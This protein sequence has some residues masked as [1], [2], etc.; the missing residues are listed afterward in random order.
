MQDI[1][2]SFFCQILSRQ[3]MKNPWD[4]NGIFRIRHL[5]SSTYYILFFLK[6]FHST[7]D[8][9]NKIGME[10]RLGYAPKFTVQ[11]SLILIYYSVFLVD[12]K[13]QRNEALFTCCWDNDYKDGIIARGRDTIFNLVGCMTRSGHFTYKM[14]LLIPNL[15]HLGN[16]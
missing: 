13:G 14:P 15:R 3:R 6:L 16:H 7:M 4:I 12:E 9:K 5:Y 10:K 8:K 2:R 11:L 1:S